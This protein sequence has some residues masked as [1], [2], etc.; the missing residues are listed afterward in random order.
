MTGGRVLARTLLLGALAGVSIWWATDEPRAAERNFLYV[1]AALAII[2]ALW[3][4]ADAW[5][6]LRRRRNGRPN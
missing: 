5:V 2:V 4:V 1:L 6:I 3:G